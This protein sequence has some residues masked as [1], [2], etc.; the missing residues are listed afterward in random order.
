MTKN[1]PRCNKTFECQHSST[2]WC[3]KYSITDNVRLYLKDNFSD[4]LCEN[5]L[6]EI[7]E[8]HK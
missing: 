2:C 6:K 3:S 1:C 5:C 4:C 7:I 8:S